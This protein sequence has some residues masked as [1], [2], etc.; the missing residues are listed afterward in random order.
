MQNTEKYFMRAMIPCCCMHALSK[1]G[2]M[3]DIATP[4]LRSMSILLRFFDLITATAENRLH[5]SMTLQT[6]QEYRELFRIQ[7][8][9]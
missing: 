1:L 7:V 6:A 2:A 3:F 8:E 5:T 4:I 9:I